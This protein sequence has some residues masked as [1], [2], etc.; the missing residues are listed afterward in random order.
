VRGDYTGRIARAKLLAEKF[1]ASANLLAFYIK[2]ATLQSQIYSTAAHTPPSA[3]HQALLTLVKSHAP[4]PLILYTHN[5]LQSA[6]QLETLLTSRDQRERSAP[7]SRFFTRVLQQPYAEH[8]SPQSH[9]PT[10][11][12]PTCPQCGSNPVAAILRGEG[13][14]A[15]RSLLCSLCATEWPFRRVLCPNCPEENK[16]HLP[17]YTSAAINHVRVEACDTC[18][19]YI[20]SIDLTK[21]GFA[22]P[23]VDE[24]ATVAL[25]VWADEHGYA[26]LEPNILGM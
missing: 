21:D 7:E 9:V 17:I 18:H 11:S 20:K 3:H 25:D 10:T 14:G 12:T 6:A 22:I 15:K 19:T 4:E 23:E 8:Q 1:P 13:D 16:D 2:I 5:Y 26:K 24:L